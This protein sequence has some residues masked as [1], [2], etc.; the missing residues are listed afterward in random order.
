MIL[1]NGAILAT[2]GGP[3]SIKA[4]SNHTG[5]YLSSVTSRAGG[6]LRLLASDEGAG[7]GVARVGAKLLL[8]AQQ[9]VVLGQAVRT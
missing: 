8:D 4:P 2:G 9:R 7:P 1:E 6:D 3:I 5:A